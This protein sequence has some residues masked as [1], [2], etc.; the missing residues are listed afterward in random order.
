[1]D[2]EVGVS[3][4]ESS[5]FSN[6]LEVISSADD[7]SL[8]LVGDNHALEDAA[9][10]RHVAGEGALLV[11]VDTVYGSLGGLEAKADVLVVSQS[12]LRLLAEDSLGALED[13][14]LLLGGLLFLI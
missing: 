10:D 7:G 9:S 3:L 12:L 4:L 2:G 11:D 6:V 14:V 13:S 1:M 8:H 5:V